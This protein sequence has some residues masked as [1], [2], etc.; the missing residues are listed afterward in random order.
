MGVAEVCLRAKSVV[1]VVVEQTSSLV[2]SHE[3]DA[4]AR[5]GYRQIVQLAHQCLAKTESEL[6]RLQTSQYR[7]KTYLLKER[8]YIVMPSCLLKFI[9]ESFNGFSNN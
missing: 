2:A 8:E 7:N 5:F 6:A 4:A 9:S 1:A 3:Y